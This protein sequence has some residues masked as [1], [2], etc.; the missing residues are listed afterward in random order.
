MPTSVNHTLINRDL[1]GKIKINV[2]QFVRKI[3]QTKIDSAVSINSS[4]HD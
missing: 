3:K 1:I 4:L 2:I